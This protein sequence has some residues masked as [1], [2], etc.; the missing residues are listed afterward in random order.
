MSGEQVEN[1]GANSGPELA[2]N[3]ES[4]EYFAKGFR[5]VAR[6]LCEEILALAYNHELKASLKSINK[7]AGA[8][9]AMGDLPDSLSGS[10]DPEEI[11]KSV[12]ATFADKTV[13]EFLAEISRLTEVGSRISG[14][15]ND[16]SHVRGAPS[17]PQSRYPVVRNEPSAGQRRT[18]R[19]SREEVVDAVAKVL[20]A[21]RKPMRGE[22]I[23]KVL[24]GEDPNL[25]S[26]VPDF[27]VPGRGEP[28]NL[29]A[30][31]INDLNLGDAGTNRLRR[32]TGR[33]G[34]W[35]LAAWSEGTDWNG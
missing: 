16:V 32:E 19:P 10:L 14:E 28:N 4:G 12:R 25:R 35:S 24:I 7:N 18:R 17:R 5:M 15:Q 31:L 22:E 13:S 20:E 1:Y 34:K 6:E 9:F 30:H 2:D 29:T 11:T 23:H 27:K 21:K 26:P 8:F 3:A 33:A